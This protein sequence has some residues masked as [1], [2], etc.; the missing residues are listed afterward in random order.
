MTRKGII[1]KLDTV[2]S[3]YIRRKFADENGIVKCYTCNKKA[4]WKGEG[5]QNGHFI[6]RSSRALRWDED[7][8]RPQCYAC[9]CM[10][11]G[12]NYLF[13][14]NLNKEFGYDKADELLTKS[15]EIVK[16]TS[17]ELLEMIE[18]YNNELKKI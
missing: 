13:A 3:E 15:R 9:N 11:Y 16:H 7:N 10:R 1:K 18:H 6:S 2:F 14:M 17:P 4:Y 12:Q 8:C 5:M